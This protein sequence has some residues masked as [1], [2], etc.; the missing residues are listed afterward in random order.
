MLHHQLPIYKKGCELVSL[1]FNVQRQMPRD[2]KRSL[3]EKITGHC[4]DMVDLM[5]LANA[6][7]DNFTL[8][9]AFPGELIID[10]FAGGGGPSRSTGTGE[11]RPRSNH[12]RKASRMKPPSMP[13]ESELFLF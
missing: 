5:A 2:F 12:L 11:L 6:T 7:R 3:G 10:N 4:T 1:A 8:P 9:L 13:G